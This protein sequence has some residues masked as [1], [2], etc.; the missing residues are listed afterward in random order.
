LATE[1]ALFVLREGLHGLFCTRLF[2]S[3]AQTRFSSNKMLFSRTLVWL[4]F[5]SKLKYYDYR[6]SLNYG[7]ERLF[8]IQ[9]K[10]GALIRVGHLIKGAAYLIFPK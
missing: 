3:Y 8:K 7:P 5:I 2:A 9:D 1:V 4:N 6:K 10:T